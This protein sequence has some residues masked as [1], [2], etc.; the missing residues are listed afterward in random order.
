[1]FFFCFFV[2]FSPIVKRLE[3]LSGKRYIRKPVII[4]INAYVT[5]SMC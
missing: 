5:L 1:M 3:L 2:F 4:I